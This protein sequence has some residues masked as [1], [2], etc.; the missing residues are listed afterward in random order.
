MNKPSFFGLFLAASMV[1]GVLLVGSTQLGIVQ[2]STNISG[3]INPAVTWT[4][5]GSPLMLTGTQNS[6]FHSSHY[7]CNNCDYCDCNIRNITGKAKTSE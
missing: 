6:R 1:I 2:A 5:S 7:S 4:P 3:I